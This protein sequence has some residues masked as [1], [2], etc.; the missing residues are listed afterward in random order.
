MGLFKPV[1]GN[2]D[3]L[4]NGLLKLLVGLNEASP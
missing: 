3:E 1:Y 2:L 4:I